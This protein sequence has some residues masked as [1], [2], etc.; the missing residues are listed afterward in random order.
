MQRFIVG[1]L[2]CLV[3]SLLLTGCEK[4]PV[5]VRLADIESYAESYP[6]SA[7][8]AL[9]NI[10]PI[11]LNTSRLLAQHALMLTTATS[12]CKIKA[13]NDSLIRIAVDYFDRFG[14]RKEKFLSY[15]YLGRVSED[16]EDYETAMQCYVEAESIHSKDISL[17]YL[18]SLQLRKAVLYRNYYDYSKAVEAYRKAQEYASMCDWKTNYFGA[19]V[20]ELTTHILFEKNAESDSLIQS[21]IPFHEEMTPKNQMTFDND[22]IMSLFQRQVNRDSILTR[23]H[24]F[25]KDYACRDDFPWTSVSFYYSLSG[26]YSNAQRALDKY[27]ATHS[28]LDSDTGYLRASSVLNDSLGFA[29]NCQKNQRILHQLLTDELYGKSVSNLRFVEE[30]K[31]HNTHNQQLKTTLWIFSVAVILLGFLFILI[32]RKRRKQKEELSWLYSSLQEEYEGMSNML[33]NNI[34]IQEEAR[35]MLGQ[36]VKSLGHFL[37]IEQPKSLE[38]VSDQLDS[39][40]NNRK[41]LLET[42]GLLYAVYY[43]TFVN[44]LQEFKLSNGEIGYCCLLILGFRAGEIGDVINRRSSYHISSAIR[45]KVG[46]E[47]NDTNLAIFLKNLFKETES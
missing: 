28:K 34:N 35:I 42:I 25:E 40:T 37:S 27:S 39:L 8:Q 16:L 12:R 2:A 19:K 43:P 47:P 44:Q 14:P 33:K 10:D 13:P 26:D 30:E 29:I 23:L 46:L 41:E 38:R 45:R 21:I 36:R 1:L 20:G 4:N 3:S 15:Y 6:D 24:D 17:R 22:V 11:F 32:L 18:T 31:A 5:R 7:R 9:E